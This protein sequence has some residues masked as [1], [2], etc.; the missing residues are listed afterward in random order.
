MA[1]FGRSRFGKGPFGRSDTGRDLLI[2]SFPNEYFD[3]SLVLDANETL[4]DNNKDPLLKLLKTYSNAVFQRRTEIDDLQNI[5]DPDLSPLDLVRLFGNT[6]G[7]GVDKND[8]EFLQR[9]FLKN[10][11]QWLQIKASTKGYQ[12]RGL[13]SGFDVEVENFWRIDPSYAPKIPTFFQYLFRPVGADAS[14]PFFLHTNQPPGTFAGTPT[15]EDPTYSKSSYVKVVFSVSVYKDHFDY[16]KLLDLVILKIRDVVGIHHEL[17][18]PEFRVK[19]PI[20]ANIVPLIPDIDESINVFNSNVSCY[21]DIIPSDIEPTD[22]CPITVSVLSTLELKLSVFPTITITIPDDELVNLNAS[23][24]AYPQALSQEQANL[25]LT[26]SVDISIQKES[27]TL[28]VINSLSLS[29]GLLSSEKTTITTAQTT[30][31]GIISQEITKAGVSASVTVAIIKETDSIVINVPAAPASGV[32]IS[33]SSTTSI[34]A[35]VFVSGATATAVSVV[36]V[37]VANYF[38]LI[39]ADTVMLDSGLGVND[40]ILAA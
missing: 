19:L 30:S 1:G 6:L 29:A 22:S 11:S 20:K 38:D 36:R 23:V 39:P 35:N 14:A 7:V 3:A 16:N 28:S 5:L 37:P 24:N 8:P 18:S 9:S 10:A 4:K 34:V 33:E 15:T 31:Q 32:K 40:T 2:E 13:A 17:T 27:E 12:V 25:S 26:E 21:F